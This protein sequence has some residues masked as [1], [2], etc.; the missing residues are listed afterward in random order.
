MESSVYLP[1]SSNMGWFED[2][3][4]HAALERYLKSAVT[5]FD[6]VVL[7]DGR[8]HLSAG[9]DGQGMV[10]NMPG[11]SF[12][13]D[14][15]AFKPYTKGSAFGVA[16]GGTPV[17]RSTSAFSVDVDYMPL[18][19]KAGIQDAD[20]LEW[21]ADSLMPAVKR[22]VEDLA[23]R[24]IGEGTHD[25]ALPANRY[26]RSQ[27]L[28]RYYQDALLSYFLEVPMLLDRSVARLAVSVSETGAG[29]LTPSLR[30]TAFHAWRALQLP[31]FG[32]WE[33]HDIL[34][35]RD[36]ASGRDFR[37]MI[38]RV[39]ESVASGMAEG[40]APDD[41]R[42]LASAAIATELVQEIMRRELTLGK[43]ALSVTMNL[44]PLNLGTIAGTGSELVD[45]LKQRRSWISVLGYRKH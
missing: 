35:F 11:N 13:G 38:T 43:I 17:L 34:A 6:R 8:L 45:L 23:R 10:W 12:S 29:K 41:L 32:D 39:S 25:D 1:L 30:E 20:F 37:R 7:E 36:S 44:V 21:R 22:P 31:D 15:T 24:E 26:L 27:L 16:V 40:A 2:A 42:Q 9:N 33:W 5:V 18:V 4:S 28:P 19:A 14:R 3:T